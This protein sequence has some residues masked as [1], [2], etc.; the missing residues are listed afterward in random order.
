MTWKYDNIF[1]RRRNA[2]VTIASVWILLFLSPTSSQELYT[3]TQRFNVVDYEA[4]E[5]FPYLHHFCSDCLPQI[6]ESPDPLVSY[7]WNAH[8]NT[9]QL[10][11]YRTH[12]L[13]S[14]KVIPSHAISEENLQNFFAV[15]EQSSS[16][17]NRTVSTSLK[18]YQNCTIILD[19]GLERAAWFEL[20]MKT[21]PNANVLASL[22]EFNEPYPDKTRELSKYGDIT[23]RLE[24]NDELY[25]GVRFTFLYISFSHNIDRSNQPNGADSFNSATP[26][27]PCVEILDISLVAKIKPIAYTGSFRS[28]NVELTKTWYTGAYGVRLNMEAEGFN[29]VLMERG[30]RVAIQGDGHPTIDTALVAFASENVFNMVK[31]VLQQTDSSHKHVVDDSIMAYPLYWCISAIDYYWVSGDHDFFEE[32]LTPDIQVLVDRRIDD[33]L[34]PDLDITWF[35]WD[36]RVGNGWCYHDNDKC[37]R[38]AHLAFAALVIRVCNDFSRAL[39]ASGQIDLANQYY[40]QS[41]TMSQKLR[42]VPEYPTGFGVH[43]AANVLNAVGTATAN[44]TEYWMTTT[45]NDPITICSF[46]QFNQYWILQAFGNV[47]DVNAMEHALESIPLCWGTMMKLGKGCFWELSSPEWLRFLNDGD[48]APHMP[49]YCHPWA[50]GVTTWLSHVLGGL[51]PAT[52]GY[53]KFAALPYVSSTHPS[54]STRVETPEGTILMNVTLRD[55][56]TIEMHVDSPVSGIVGLRSQVLGLHGA[57]YPLAT[58]LALVNGVQAKQISYQKARQVL[59]DKAGSEG[60]FFFL[61]VPGG[62]SS[63][64][65]AKYGPFP[66]SNVLPE[67]ASRYLSATNRFPAPK[68]PATIDL[69]RSSQGNGLITYG[70]DGYMLFGCGEG[71][72]DIEQ[73]PKYVANLTAIRHGFPGYINV[74][75]EFVGYS[76]TNP[77]YLPLSRHHA[78]SLG[79]RGLGRINLEDKGAGDLNCILLDVTISDDLKPVQFMLSVYFAAESKFNRH[80]IRIMD[81][82]TFNLIAPTPLIDDYVDGVWLTVRYNKSIRLKFLDMKGILISAVAFSSR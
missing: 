37:N 35:G 78:R 67:Q 14:Y 48:A 12:Q 17:Q 25:E 40:E 32:Q 22:S 51:T 21:A 8:V 57:L 77:V 33:F 60:A 4:P 81:G 19:W 41:A 23:Y 65:E 38:E 42:Q 59:Q 58:N 62:A 34:K 47:G 79:Q 16:T 27:P 74:R 49:S 9:S 53:T 56:L 54:V 76:D 39:W 44:E 64:I 82:D 45:L 66:R 3:T 50:S 75:R 63:L 10:Q 61:W 28:S 7:T 70:K 5:P 30:D 71:G 18:V 36:D 43:A 52:P 11:V 2:F 72:G 6:D 68:Y 73:L 1:A 55:D 13:S 31:N 26:F 46:S 29:T 69:D 80:A 15:R 24:T 20:Q